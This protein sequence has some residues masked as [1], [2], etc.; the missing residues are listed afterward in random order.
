M[1]NLCI[2]EHDQVAYEESLHLFQL[3]KAARSAL[4]SGLCCINNI[5]SPHLHYSLC[6]VNNYVFTN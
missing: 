5:M 4:L 3:H 1:L 2:S 6:R